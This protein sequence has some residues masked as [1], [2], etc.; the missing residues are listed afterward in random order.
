MNHHDQPVLHSGKTTEA[1]ARPADTA[2]TPLKWS[3]TRIAHAPA[4]GVWGISWLRL[5]N[6]Q[7]SFRCPRARA[8]TLIELLVVIAIIAILAALLLAALSR[9]KIEGD[10]ITCLNNVKQWC[11][12]FISYKEDNEDNLPREGHRQTQPGIIGYDSWAQ[13]RDTNNLDVW[14]NGVP[15]A[16]GV[17]PAYKYAPSSR[18]AEFYENRLFHCPAASFPS[19]YLTDTRP[20]FSL[21]MNSQLIRYPNE[22]IR[23]PL[24][25]NPTDTV[26]F[27]D[28]RVNKD[29]VKVDPGQ[30]NTYLG[31]P[32]AYARGFAARH[33]KSGNLGFCDG[34][35]E[36][37]LGINVVGPNGYSTYSRFRISRPIWTANPYISPDNPSSD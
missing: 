1:A 9:A 13:V 22:A 21:V 36:S 19:G 2:T 35:A 24:I 15:L 25:Q 4:G 20:Y 28:A 7:R 31:A 29:E 37:W 23:Y 17:Q 16:M 10:R 27:L 3:V 14:Y 32:A 26:L 11:T 34:H 30:H 6:S 8:F 12:G 33:G 18:N 5:A